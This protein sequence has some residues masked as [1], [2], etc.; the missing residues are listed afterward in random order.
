MKVATVNKHRLRRIL[1]DELENTMN[2]SQVLGK[3]EA[4]RKLLPEEIEHELSKGCKLLE[5]YDKVRKEEVSQMINDN[6]TWER[7]LCML[8][9]KLDEVGGHDMSNLKITMEV[10]DE[11]PDI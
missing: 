6:R 2:R 1:N 10:S 9:L 5:A 11:V 7:F 3:V 4:G 8:I